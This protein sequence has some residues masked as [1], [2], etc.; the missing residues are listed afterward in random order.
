MIEHT[1]LNQKYTNIA[2]IYKDTDDKTYNSEPKRKVFNSFSL[3]S[4]YTHKLETY[5]LEQTSVQI[6]LHYCEYCFVVVQQ[7]Q[8][9]A[10]IKIFLINPKYVSY[11]E[12]TLFENAI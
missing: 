9:L 7:L 10:E 2:K 3:F 8:Q 11:S 6:V 5:L 12:L 1:N 4:K